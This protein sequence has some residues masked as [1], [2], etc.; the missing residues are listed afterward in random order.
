MGMKKIGFSL[1]RDLRGGFTWR[2][3]NFADGGH[4]KRWEYRS[5]FYFKRERGGSLSKTSH[6]RR[7]SFLSKPLDYPLWA[8]F[9]TFPKGHKESGVF[10]YHMNKPRP[11]A[12]NGKATISRRRKIN[13]GEYRSIFFPPYSKRKR[14][15]N[16]R[17]FPG[18]DTSQHYISFSTLEEGDSSLLHKQ[19]FLFPFCLYCPPTLS[20]LLI[21]YGTQKLPPLPLPTQEYDTRSRIRV[22][23]HARKPSAFN[24]L[25]ARAVLVL[26]EEQELS[27]GGVMVEANKM[28]LFV[29]LMYLIKGSFEFDSRSS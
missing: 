5:I 20:V 14:K 3:L 19:L 10:I 1:G 16:L 18:H 15:M 28:G 26:L 13:K 24:C 17:D 12:E 11:I 22:S 29:L 7:Y 4:K 27:G 6:K 23:T 21:H 2:N 9:L 8:L 25:A